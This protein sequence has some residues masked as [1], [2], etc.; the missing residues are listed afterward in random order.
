[1]AGGSIVRF[2]KIS[3]KKLLVSRQS[4]PLVLKANC[5]EIEIFYRLSMN[6]VYY[7]PSLSIIYFVQ[8]ELVDVAGVIKSAL[9]SLD[10]IP[11]FEQIYLDKHHYFKGQLRVKLKKKEAR[12]AIV[13]MRLSNIQVQIST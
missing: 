5:D 12:A 4:Q 2:D 11:V 13:A 1:M 6:R 8:S 10:V 7:V 3:A 9:K